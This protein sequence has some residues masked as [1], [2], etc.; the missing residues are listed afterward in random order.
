MT[1][2]KNKTVS[3]EVE[4]FPARPSPPTAYCM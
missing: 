1:G 3:D 4:Q 2:G